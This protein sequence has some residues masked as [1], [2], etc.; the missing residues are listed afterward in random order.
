MPIKFV[1][2]AVVMALLSAL[3]VWSALA[4]GARP[5]PF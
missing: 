1:I 3:V 5:D 2:L 4:I